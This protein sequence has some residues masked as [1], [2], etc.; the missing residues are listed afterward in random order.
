[1]IVNTRVARS[2]GNRSNVSSVMR[3]VQMNSAMIERSSSPETLFQVRGWKERG[4]RYH[5]LSFEKKLQENEKEGV[6]MG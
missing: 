2:M 5:H 3:V 6:A 4:P 1:M